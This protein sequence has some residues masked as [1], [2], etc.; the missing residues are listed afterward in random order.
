MRCL[1]I[2]QTVLGLSTL[3]SA[4]SPGGAEAQGVTFALGDYTNH[5]GGTVTAAVT[6][7]NF[8]NVLGAQFTLQWDP[9]VL[10]YQSVG[11]F[12]SGVTGLAAGDFGT[13][14]SSGDLTLS[15][16]S[17]S[18][19][20]VTVPDGTVIFTVSFLV[21]GSP[22]SSST[23]ALPNT[24]TTPT[25]PQA[26]DGNFNLL[27]FIAVNGQVQVPRLAIPVISPWPTASSITYGQALTNSTLSG[28]AAS[29]GGTFS[30]SA[31]ATVPPAGTYAASVTFNPTDTADYQSVTGSVNV[32][33]AQVP[34][35][36]TGVTANTKVYDGTTAAALSSNNV[37]LAG[38]I[39]GDMVALDTNGYT[40]T[41]GSP[42]VGSG[43][44]V[45]VTGLT[46]SGASAANYTLVQPVLAGNITPA[47]LTIT[48]MGASKVY[49]QTVTFAGTEFTAGRLLNSD[50][51]TSVTLT[52]AGAAATATLAGSPYSIVPSAAVGTGLGNYT[53][54]Y[55]SGQ[56]TITAAPLTITANS[57]SKV[58]G[59]TA[60]FA[61]TEFITA[62]LL[63]GDTVASV[64]LT[65]AGAA[66]TATVAGS[67]YNIVPSAAVGTGLG[68]YTIAYANGQLTLTAAPLTITANNRS[69]VYGQTVTFAGTE[70][71]TSGL[72]NSDAV[73]S[74]TLTSAGAAGTATVAG[75][76]YNI[77]P[78]VAVGTGLGNY[79][80][81]YANGQ[82]TLT[83]APLTITAN[84]ASKVYGQ[85]VTFA[86][87]EFATSGLLN[88][89][90][91][92][93][94]TLTSAG[95]AATATLAGSPYSIVP[96]A[97]VG[98]GL[99]NYTIAYANGQLTVTAAPLT[100]AANNRS[101]VYGQTVTFAGTEFSTSGL[102]NSDA[103]TSVTLTSAG[104]AAT[105]TVAGSP[106]SIVP[107][108]AVGTGLGNYAI[109]Y[110]N[111]QLALTAAPLTITPNNRSKVY[112]QTVTFAG[113]EFTT[114]GLV[115][116]DTVT[117]VTLT[118]AGAA[119]TA[120]VAGSPY[121]I[122]PSVAL[123]TGLGNYTIA[124]ANGQLTVTA[125]PLTI[126]ANN[127]SKAY[128]Q[129]VT[130][131]GTE[132]TTSGPLNADTVTSVTLTSAGA[133]A[134]AAVAGSPYSIVPSAAVGTGLGN[135]TI[136]YVNGVLTVSQATP[137]I[138]WANPA[139]ILVGTPLGA[140]QL[141]ATANTAGSFVYNPPAGTVL[142]AGNGQ[143]LSTTFTPSDSADYTT[144]TASVTI[145]AGYC[146]PPPSG[147]VSWWRGEGNAYDLVGGNT[148]IPSNGVSYVS[149]EV[150]QA[151]NFDA[152]HAMV[153]IGNP[154]NLQLQDF[155]I[156]SWVQRGS[157]AVVTTDP[158]TPNGALLFSYGQNGY[159]FGL[160]ADG[161]LFLSQIGGSEITSSAALTD[162]TFHHVAVTK[163]GGTVVFYIDGT[164]Y[165]ASGSYNPSF[166][167]ATPSAIGG[168]ADN[169]NGDDNA[170]FLGAI[171][172]MSIYNRALATDEI[173]SIF[174]AGSAGKCIP[175]LS[176]TWAN[177]ADIV[178]GT[179]LSGTQLD[180]TANV[181][182][183]FNYNPPLGSLLAA[184]VDQTLSVTFTPSD[185]VDYSPVTTTVSIN[186]KQAPLA[187]TANSPSKVYGQTVTFAGTEFTTAGLF[188][189]DTVT[190]VTLTSAGAAATA[191]VAGSPYSIVPSAA[192]GTGLDNYTIAYA[193]GELTVTPAPLTVTA[194]SASKVY[195]QTVTFAGTEFATAGLFNGDTVTSV[196]LT[197]LGA[198]TTA[199]VAGSPYSIVP[200]AAVGTGLGNYTVAYANG[201]L[202][203]NPA[204][205]T[206]TANNKSKTYGQTVT[207]AGTEFTSAGLLNGDSATSVTLTSGG[208]AA[209]AGV[210]GSPYAIVP[211]AA[212]GTGLGNY[213]ISYS[214]GALTVNP[215]SLT[216]T[217]ANRSKTYGQT[218]TFTG[219]EFTSA[220]LQ[221]SEAVGSVTL[222]VSGGGGPAT[223]WPGAYTITPSAATGG[224][225]SANN[226]AISYQAGTLTVN[227]A[228]LTVT[229]DNAIKAYGQTNPVFTGTIS[230]IQNGDSF[231]ATYSCGATV[232]SAPGTYPIVPTL[233]SPG[234]LQTNYQVTLV[235]GTL[236]VLS[237]TPV[238]AWTNPA[239]IVYGTPL[240]T[241]ELNAST[242]V[243]GSFAYSPANGTVLFTGTNTLSAVFTP[244]DIAHY[245]SVTSSVSLV[246]LPALLTVT[247]NNA[248][249]LYGQTNPVFTGTI[250]GIQNGDNIS[251]TYT[252]SATPGSAAGVYGIGAKVVSPGNLA[253]NYETIVVYGTLTV[254]PTAPI[255]SW[256]NPAP[257]VYGTPLGTNQLNA[258]ASIP[259]SFVYSPTNGT[260]LFAGTNTLSVVFTPNDLTD[261]TSLTTSVSLVVS[262]A[263]LTVTADNGTKAYGQTNPVFTGTISGIQNG[264]NISATYSCSAIT[265]SPPGDYPIVPTPV[266]P[267]D[268]LTNYQV[269]LVNGTLAVLLA[270]P[271]V[272]W[273]NPAPITYGT[274]L[275]ANQLNATGSLLGSFAY[276][277]AN[278][279]VLFTGTNTLSVLFTPVYFL[280]YSSLTG[281][282]S[283]VVLPAPLTVTAN[284]ATRVYGQA[285]PVF[286]A[287]ITGIQNGDNISATCTCAAT[288]SSALGTYPIVPTLV[289]PANLQ[290]NYQV[291]L[292][293]GTLTVLPAPPIVTWTNPAPIAY[294]TPLGTNEL[295][296]GASIPGSFV[297]SPTN[298]T[299][300]FTGTNTLS[301]VFT[302]N[303]LTDYTSL[304][305][306]VSLV[307]S[308]APL[309]VTANN[310]ARVYGQTNP[311]FTGTITGTQNGDNIGA[312]YTCGAAASSA[313]GT[314]PIVPTL[315]SPGNLQT[316]YQV[317]LVNGALS[318]LPAAP[319]VSWTNP[320]PIT[321]GTPLDTNQ[322]NASAS[323]AGSFVYTPTNGT[324][325]FTGT[326][327]LSVVFTPADLTDYTNLTSGVSL[328][329]LPGLLT[330]TADNATRVYGQTNPVF[331]GAL[332]G[333]T[334]GDD[335]TAIFTCSA[336]ATSP[337][338]PYTITAGLLD[339]SHRLSNYTVITNDG[340]LTIVGPTVSAVLQNGFVSF[341]WP[342]TAGLFYQVQFTTNLF[343]PSWTNLGAPI[344]A[345]NSV[346]AALDEIEPGP[347]RFYRVVIVP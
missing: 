317:T 176:V 320:A 248:T 132:F 301:V 252:C 144:A 295:N 27:T 170:S 197:S 191:T 129:T 267:L 319:I 48:A 131:A 184:A 221:N 206:V 238:V 250:T 91:V 337:P 286:T 161:T 287:T 41:F 52:S 108:A 234:N 179:E 306:S 2:V 207:F 65:S 166:Q 14:G 125:A 257:I 80:I 154:T 307:V 260:V 323:V 134:T 173:A 204:A 300:L 138:T 247:A 308:P 72:L 24:P 187:I 122:V 8:V 327:A 278:G 272:T 9:T 133:A 87:T 162:T 255:V 43:I 29:V 321:Y 345:T 217:A 55:A 293:N 62:G 277:P 109:A 310:A 101:K 328:V 205:L 180:A 333:V 50:T 239:P 46:L 181:A 21:I 222:A 298:G 289:S 10:S 143:T 121:N 12:N 45:T 244:T 5:T 103:V 53:I 258:G 6:V 11:N 100:I 274:P 185:P 245:T 165:S 269:T 237:P 242:S 236:T 25:P 251:A 299:V 330:V 190:S 305:T 275:G 264:D 273:T 128:G 246:V 147:L 26:F 85:T 195:G 47:P 169:I 94:V 271:I 119:A 13:P 112:G 210:S 116:S 276:S 171:D 114:S 146:V 341:T 54:A 90:T 97:A 316:N 313:P 283:M 120:A 16:D 256:T 312:T 115:N 157:T 77:V 30:F 84:S 188:N 196:T 266:S 137:V 42:N 69:K 102:V 249:R 151:F 79:T 314:Y 73:T 338:G 93:S 263:P 172:E 344:P 208:A 297:Y 145:S 110:A 76:P 288:A 292:V 265:T 38:V 32:S 7:T 68:N 281:S 339:P 123:G 233:V 211:S 294:G 20:G 182:G 282:V 135:Y 67:P 105:A 329:V 203:V 158:T 39:S 340:V 326:N 111:G 194:N 64:T 127:R 152:D 23:L 216:I 106:Y 201:E 331:A 342:S 44:S 57:R 140:A 199:T 202:T 155:T 37:V 214:S 3:L 82:L 315:V 104:A 58:Y 259:G 334:N 117:S 183:T 33:V 175:A 229:A 198:A 215:A 95:S 254:L 86:G 186:V 22:G 49:G 240:G 1:G 268:V 70:F 88:S 284:N 324:V 279:T 163:S 253:T 34:L 28:G 200:S 148:G 174:N 262:P 213:T 36:V 228:P 59:Q 96:S 218:V 212:V 224:T 177:P 232:S 142:A 336:N 51:V 15:W 141:D 261:Y 160:L 270:T 78:S 227:L 164:P 126:T 113:T 226:Y 193:N 220:G 335:I 167:F 303:D 290:T 159:G 168:R 81:A 332:T 136:S 149:G 309:T 280:T 322:L 130:F 347:G 304:T 63:N 71:A 325:L 99:G 225:F 231:S 178:Y 189:G 343:Q 209:T 92:T 61:G 60:T 35:T 346:A 89:D 83:A 156:E 302:P 118:S 31:P 107:S 223:A 66:G 192:V 291:T 98:T 18:G 74:V 153:V 285:N 311:V 124:Y 243:A 235:N 17:T 318:V 139:A 296:A 150:G 40:A 241:N 4:L 230:G 56:L 75:S 219:T 19:S